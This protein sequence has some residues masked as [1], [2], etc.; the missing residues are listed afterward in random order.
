MELKNVPIAIGVF[1]LFL[2]VPAA[3]YLS[4]Q[5]ESLRTFTEAGKEESAVYYLWPAEAESSIGEN[6]EVRITLASPEES[7]SEAKTVLKYNPQSLDVINIE[8]GII[9]N[10]YTKKELDSVTG[11]IEIEARG[12]FKGTGTFATVTFAPKEKGETQLT[13]IKAGSEILDKNGSDI[14]QG[15]NGSV[16]LVR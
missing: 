13:L 2:T 5:P 15:I 11:Q 16:L 14:L 9:F 4:T 10:K 3:V 8:K 7:A 12:D 1:V 6:F